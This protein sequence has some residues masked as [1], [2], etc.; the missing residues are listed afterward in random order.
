VTADSV[1]VRAVRRNGVCV[2]QVAGEL[3]GMGADAFA[4]RADAAVRSLPGP[5]LVDLTGMTFIDAGGARVLDAV[6]R[7]LPGGRAASVRACPPRVRRILDIL[8]LPLDGRPPAGNS[9]VRRS[10]TPALVDEVRRARLHAAEA[11]LDASGTLAE[12]ADTRIRLAGTIERAGL[13]REQ[14]R[15]TLARSRAGRE[16][17][18]RSRRLGRPGSLPAIQLLTGRQCGPAA[19][20]NHWS[21]AIV[22]NPIV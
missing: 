12:L 17:A 1:Q 16:R 5:V 14:G 4:E 3:E 2:L 6:M 9:P 8:G 11:K 22:M 15:E 18:F 21:L 13:V 7:T 10:G 19:E 20:T